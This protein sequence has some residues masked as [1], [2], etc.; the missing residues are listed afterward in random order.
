MTKP[1]LGKPELHSNQKAYQYLY[2]M[3]SR[4]RCFT[5]EFRSWH[6]F[7]FHIARVKELFLQENFN[8]V[9]ERLKNWPTWAST[10]QC[11]DRLKRNCSQ[12]WVMCKSSLQFEIVCMDD[13]NIKC[14]SMKVISKVADLKFS[15]NFANELVGFL[16]KITYDEF[17]NLNR[18]E[19]N[20]LMTYP[21]EKEM[22]Y[23]IIYG[24]LCFV[25]HSKTS[26]LGFNLAGEMQ[27]SFLDS[28]FVSVLPEF[29]MSSRIGILKLI[30][31]YSDLDF[32]DFDDNILKIAQH[33]G[34]EITVKY[35]PNI[36]FNK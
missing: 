25:N 17:E 31:E 2:N 16:E 7:E 19:Y 13:S 34:A 21:V 14:S 8:E 27:C 28:R 32:D 26:Y 12:F 11:R 35:G 29:D 22:Q 20:S 9:W 33:V 1:S 18:L 30:H 36:S 6:F 10:R 23:F 5:E 4:Y 24:P 15:C 3:N